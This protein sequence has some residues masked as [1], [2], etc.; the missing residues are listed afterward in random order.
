VLVKDL[1]EAS[2]ISNSKMM[3]IITI[4]LDWE[5]KPS[6]PSFARPHKQEKNTDE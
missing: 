1:P 5:K 6:H 4:Q 2:I 3:C